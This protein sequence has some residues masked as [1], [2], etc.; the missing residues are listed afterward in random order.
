MER[1]AELGFRG[2]TS[3]GQ[4]RDKFETSTGQVPRGKSEHRGPDPH[5]RGQG[6]VRERDD[7]EHRAE[8]TGQFPESLSFSVNRRRFH[9][10]A[11]S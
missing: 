10:S 5:Y 8:R 11:V 1:T 7:G 6:V 4:A 3:S 9:T 2:R